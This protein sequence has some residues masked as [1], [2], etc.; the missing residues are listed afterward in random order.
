MGKHVNRKDRLG[1][2]QCSDLRG[3]SESEAKLGKSNNE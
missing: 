2:E 3:K 1:K